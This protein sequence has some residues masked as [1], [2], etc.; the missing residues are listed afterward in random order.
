M[1]KWLCRILALGA[2]LYL[3]LMPLG[4]VYLLFD[5][6]LFERYLQMTRR[7]AIQWE[8]VQL[9]QYYALWFILFLHLSLSFWAVTYLRPI[10]ANFS[11]TAYFK[12]ENSSHLRKFSQLLIVQALLTPFVSACASVLLS[13]N[14]PMGQRMLAVNLSSHE[15][16]LMVLG[17]LLWLVSQ[18]LLH[19]NQLE[20]EN[21]Q[22]I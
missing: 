22:F 11:E 7:L 15:L 16:S 8:T 4:A 14:H 5:V 12:A 18:S 6:P 21:Q 19:G 20:Q 13:Y 2:L 10:L 3:V 9:W 1:L 17:I